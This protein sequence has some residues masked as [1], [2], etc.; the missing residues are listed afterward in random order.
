MGFKEDLNHIID[1]N[2]L[3]RQRT[4]RKAVR[5][6]D[7]VTAVVNPEKP[8]DGSGRQV[9]HAYKDDVE[10]NF[11]KV[12][13]IDDSTF[14]KGVHVLV[15]RKEAFPQR[16][17][18]DANIRAVGRNLDRLALKVKGTDR[19]YARESDAKKVVRSLRPPTTRS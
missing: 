19:R 5:L 7:A 1:R 16:I 9:K 11:V 6:A 15:S 8:L 17:V 3:P 10:G 4:L 12:V 14:G 13:T 18:L 2:T